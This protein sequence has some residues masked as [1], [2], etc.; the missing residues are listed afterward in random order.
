MGAPA[1][2]DEF[3]E[4]LPF[5]HEEILSARLP[6]YRTCFKKWLRNRHEKTATTTRNEMASIVISRAIDNTKKK[7][8]KMLLPNLLLIFFHS[9]TSTVY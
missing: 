1:Y 7:M 4:L 6:S 9:V 5:L 8:A 2:R 3:A